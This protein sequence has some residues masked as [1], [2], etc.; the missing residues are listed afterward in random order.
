MSKYTTQVRFILEQYAGLT[1]AS[2]DQIIEKGW[3]YVFNEEVEF[4]DALYKRVLCKK[5]LRHFYTR[6]IGAETFELWRLWMNTKL[7]EIMP[8]Y[9]Q[10]Y[11][12]QLLEY[13]P[14]Y[15]TDMTYTGDKS[16]SGVNT[17]KSTQ[18]NDHKEVKDHM[19]A[20]T[21]RM[22]GEGT[23]ITTGETSSDDVNSHS[24]AYSD[25]PQGSLTGVQNLKYLTN[26]R[27]IDENNSTTGNYS[28]TVK[29]NHN[30]TDTEDFRE[31][32]HNDY[33]D[34]MEGN[35]TENIDSTEKYI[36][37]VVG[38]SGRSYSELIRDFRANM[39]NIDMQ[40]INEFSDC[41]LN[42]W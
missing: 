36:N 24:D 14:L 16:G 28:N 19:A 33:N 23:T 21:K 2:V 41:F 27:K 11:K 31:N 6:E 1:D 35:E 42:L 20:S 4:F 18:N 37:K 32:E 26:A 22:I 15:T 25:T 29:T 34:H 9:N 8:F 30:D 10:L 39:L 17:K 3:S 7:M 13:N 38:N 40:V 12:S 5:I